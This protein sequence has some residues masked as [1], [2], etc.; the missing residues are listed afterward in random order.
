M[1]RGRRR[2][3]WCRCPRTRR[4]RPTAPSWPA[5]PG[6]GREP[7]ALRCC[8]QHR[9]GRR[10]PRN[11]QWSCNLGHR[12]DIRRKGRDPP[13]RHTE[14]RRVAQALRSRNVYPAAGVS[15][16]FRDFSEPWT[17]TGGDDIMPEVAGADRCPERDQESRISRRADS[18]LVRRTDR[19]RSSSGSRKRRS[20]EHTS[21]LQSLMSISYAVFC[22]K[23]K[24]TKKKQ[25]KNQIQN[26]L[27]SS[28]NNI[29]IKKD[30][31]Q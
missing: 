12:P 10:P 19:R 30:K 17:Y 14:R 3:G 5:G 31:M 24:K 23:K 29:K 18:F 9:H 4:R 7:R 26:I 13:Y 11:Q 16:S 25:S 15:G 22:F 21:E 27:L 8:Q 1:S 2:A 28:Y 6:H 20:E